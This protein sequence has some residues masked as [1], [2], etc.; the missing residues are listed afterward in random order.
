MKAQ[1]PNTQCM[2]YR[3]VHDMSS[4]SLVTNN[5]Y[6]QPIWCIFCLPS[7]AGIRTRDLELQS[8]SH[9]KLDRSAIVLL[10]MPQNL[11]STFKVKQAFDKKVP[12]FQLKRWYSW[13]N[14]RKYLNFLLHCDFS[15]RERNN[16][17][18]RSVQKKTLTRSVLITLCTSHLNFFYRQI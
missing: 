17:N 8:K 1:G 18:K 12:V 9:D 13:L 2:H 6:T 10:T 11:K 14:N 3:H 5:E 15:L 7:L 16:L 4:W